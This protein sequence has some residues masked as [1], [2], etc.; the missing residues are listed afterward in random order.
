MTQNDLTIAQWRMAKDL[1]A[2]RKLPEH[3]AAFGW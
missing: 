3:L 2:A 1:E